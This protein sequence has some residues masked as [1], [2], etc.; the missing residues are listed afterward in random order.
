M[1]TFSARLHLPGRAKLPL[2]VEIDIQNELMT[3]TSG[4]RTVAVL[5]IADLDVVSKSDGFHLNVDGEDVVLIV[6]DSAR[7]A[8]EL[9]VAEHFRP[10]MRRTPPKTHQV[11]GT[12][13]EPTKVNGKLVTAPQ[14]PTVATD[15]QLTD[16]QRRIRYVA[17]ALSSESVTPAVAFAYW[18]ELLKEL[19]RR[20]GQGTMSTEVFYRLNTQLL[21]L[22]PAAPVADLTTI[23]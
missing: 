13:N 14:A 21:D 23:V 11:N 19:N 6:S 3:V 7:F 2:G 9:G 4:E 22:I 16:L 18:L 5:P 15:D 10:E 17:D 1:S 12:S 20:H 8:K